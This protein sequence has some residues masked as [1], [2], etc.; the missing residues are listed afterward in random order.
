MEARLIKNHRV[1]TE[2]WRQCNRL[3]M[4]YREIKG[5]KGSMDKKE[6]KRMR[7]NRK[8]E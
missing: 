7:D 8:M 2:K 1:S 4:K 6:I 5:R 3:R